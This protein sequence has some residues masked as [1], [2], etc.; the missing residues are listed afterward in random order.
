MDDIPSFDMEGK[1]LAYL[2]GDVDKLT[3]PEGCTLRMVGGMN[4]SIDDDDDGYSDEDQDFDDEIP[5]GLT[6]QAKFE[7]MKKEFI[8]LTLN[9]NRDPIKPG[10]RSSLKRF[11]AQEEDPDDEGDFKRSF[12]S[13]DDVNH[14]HRSFT[15]TLIFDEL[16]ADTT[17]GFEEV[18]SGRIFKRIS[19]ASVGKAVTEDS[20]VFYHCAFWSEKSSDPF[21][22]SWVRH[23][24]IATDMENDSILPG[25]Y[26]LLLTMKEGES[27]E[28]LI[29]PEAAFGVLGAMPR[30]PRNAT[31]FCLCE[32]VKIVS[33][34]QLTMLSRNPKAAQQDGATFEDFFEA[35]N[36]ARMRGNHFFEK[37]HYSAALQRYKSGIR[38]LEALTYKD[39]PEEDKAK[40]LLVRLYNNAAKAANNLGN[41]RLALSACKQARLITH[42][43]DPKIHWNRLTAWKRWGHMDKAYGVARRACQ[44]FHDDAITQKTFMREAEA[45]KKAM[46]GEQKERDDLYRLMGKCLI[47]Q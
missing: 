46:Q 37:K 26:E 42:G 27:C 40:G 36:Q 2:P 8:S 22:S 20:L 32:V 3:K 15:S 11:F 4:H 9:S 34:D 23:S 43:E 33:K 39:K 31:I 47:N 28:A 18:S 38:I 5:V 21:D 12:S 1:K 24:V 30:I 44:L 19:R 35:S 41:P 10:N 17:K 25:L 14:I 6:E 29:R 45:L 16:I 7:R 13:H